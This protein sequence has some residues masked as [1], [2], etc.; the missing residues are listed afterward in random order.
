VSI[1]QQGQA[2]IRWLIV[3]ALIAGGVWY[4]WTAHRDAERPS[5]Q[6]AAADAEPEVV[7]SGVDVA[8]PAD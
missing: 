8:E 5:P 3:A 1:E 4:S 2:P 7:R 6:A